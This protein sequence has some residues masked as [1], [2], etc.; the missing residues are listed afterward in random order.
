MSHI[1]FQ[2]RLWCSVLEAS[3]V[4][5]V[6]RT[7]IYELM[8]SG[9]IHSKKEGKRRLISVQSLIERHETAA[10]GDRRP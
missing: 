6:G 10:K 5:G 8:A 7:K 2:E 9:G 1:P 4:E 3:Q